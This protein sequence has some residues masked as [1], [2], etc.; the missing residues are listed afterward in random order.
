MYY[1]LMG[2]SHVTWELIL[3]KKKK[4]KKLEKEYLPF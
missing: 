4:K 2:W 1:H 3:G